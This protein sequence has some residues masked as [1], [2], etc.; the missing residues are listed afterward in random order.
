MIFLFFLLKASKN[1]INN[2]YYRLSRMYHP[3]KHRDS[4]Q[5]QEA[6][7]LFNRAKKAHEV[8]SDEQKR[9]IYDSLGEKGLET[10]DWKVAVRGKSAEEIRDE[11]EQIKR[12]R[13]E[14]LMQQRTNPRGSLEVKIDATEMFVT[15]RRKKKRS[16]DLS[17]LLS[18]PRLSVSS[19]AI[20]Q[21]VDVPMG[22]SWHSSLSGA[23]RSDAQQ[24]SGSGQVMANVRRQFGDRTFAELQVSGGQ[25]PMFVARGSK[26]IS[27]KSVVSSTLTMHFMDVAIG[28]NA[29]FSYGRQFSKYLVGYLTW[30][31]GYDSAMSSALIYDR[32][33]NRFQMQVQVGMKDIFLALSYLRRLEFNN[34]RLKGAVKLSVFG[35]SLEYGCQTKLSKHSQIGAGMSIMQTGNI[36][37]KLK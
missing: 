37:L 30:K 28:G 2:A 25:G 6:V 29:E 17:A 36:S 26:A 3:D 1:E 21:A 32:D 14:R 13:Q 31:A 9:A 33:K 8:L 22:S 19:M 11:F 12:K 15:K 18:L 20:T 10:S 27:K 16:V 5:K 24:R 4:K 34:T 35:T 7:E 23:L